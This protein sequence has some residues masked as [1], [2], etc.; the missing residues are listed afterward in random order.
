MT[1]SI[2]LDLHREPVLGRIF[3]DK[4]GCVV[5]V[6]SQGEGDLTLRLQKE[7]VIALTLLLIKTLLQEPAAPCA[8]N[9]ERQGEQ[10]ALLQERG[11]EA[12]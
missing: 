2:H 10:E 4:E 9:A 12:R 3:F 11:K 7:S 5:V 6:L 8:S 1:A